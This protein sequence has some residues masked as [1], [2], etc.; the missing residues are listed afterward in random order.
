[1][2]QDKVKQFVAWGHKL[3]SHTHSYIHGAFIKAFQHLGYKTLWLDDSDDVSGIDFEATLFLTEAQVNGKIPIRDDCFYIL[4]NCDMAK[5]S[6]IP[7][8]NKMILQV[9]TDDVI[10]CHGGKPVEGHRGCFYLTDCLFI[11]WGTDLFPD[12]INENIKKVKENQI[13]TKRELNFVGMGIEPW[14]Q[15]EKFCKNNK[16]IYKQIGGFSNTN[17]DFNTNMR[18]IQ[19]SII[20][21]AVQCKWQ[22]DNSYIPCRIFKN[23][24]YGKM[25]M[26]NNF[27]VY[28]L[29][30]KKILY[31]TDINELMKLG[32]DFENKSKEEKDN[33]LIPL[34]EYV[35]DSHT[36]LN[37]VEL[38][39]WFFNNIIKV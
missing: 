8:S 24:S 1:M 13:V 17:V 15:V 12:E 37:R 5:F 14:D 6:S 31:S 23:I 19:E 28:E 4:H 21:P 34:M 33:I 16:I 26:T 18:L 35:R 38:I 10:K 32:L 25:G 22:V 39:F 27:R 9:Y 36:Y 30:D 11:P 20:A 29:F 7:K 2:I 3:H